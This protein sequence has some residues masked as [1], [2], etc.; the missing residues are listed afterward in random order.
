MVICHSGL[1]ASEHSGSGHTV[2]SKRKG[3]HAEVAVVGFAHFFDIFETSCHVGFQ[4]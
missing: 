3:P 1:P 2:D 4:L